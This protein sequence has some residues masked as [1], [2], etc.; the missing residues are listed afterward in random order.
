MILRIY[1]LMRKEFLH[2]VRDPRTLVVMFLMPM[3]Q[4]LFLG[5]GATSDIAHLTTAVADSDKSAASRELIDAY[6]AS[7]YF[8]IVSYVDSERDIEQ[9]IDAGKVRAGLIIPPDYGQRVASGEQAEVAFIIDGSDPTVANTV[10]AASQSVGQAQSMRI[11]RRQAHVDLNKLPGLQVQPRV[12]YNPDMRSA[13]FMVPGL[14]G[15]V[16]YFLTT[17][18]TAMSIVREREQGT[19]EQLIVTPIRPIELVIGK[20][21]PYVFIAFFDMLEVLAL[22]VFWF[23]VPIHG[24]LGLLLGLSAIFLMTSLGIGIFISSAARSQQEAMMLTYFTMLPSI[25]LSG[26]L[27]PIEAMP[28][29][30]QKLTYLIPLRYMLIVIRGIILKGVGLSLLREQVIILSGFGIGLMALAASR[31]RKKLD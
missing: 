2:I 7:S 1:S 23:K 24:S 14:I 27:F 21:V 22:G 4:L 10:L 15:T 9:L 8:N 18:L 11:I 19:I 28:V 16:I 5:Y 29:W 3:V 17:M 6:R 26:Y 30:L 31:F 25:F 13:N 12:W 20:I